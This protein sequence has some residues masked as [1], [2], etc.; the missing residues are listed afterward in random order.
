M[1]QPLDP[2]QATE[3]WQARLRA[4]LVTPRQVAN[5]AHWATKNRVDSKDFSDQLDAWHRAGYLEF[6][7]SRPGENRYVRFTAASLVGER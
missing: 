7:Q 5:L 1:N 4:H 6:T 3:T 2:D